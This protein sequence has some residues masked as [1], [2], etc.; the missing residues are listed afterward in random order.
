LLQKEI[1]DL[2]WIITASETDALVLE[3]TLIKK[4]S[5]KY[6]VRLKDDKRYPWICVTVSE[7]FPRVFIARNPKD[8]GNRY[9]GPFVDV[10]ATRHFLQTIYK[11]FPVRKKNL[12]LPLKKPAR[13]C[14]NFHIGRCLGPCQGNVSR[15]EYGKLVEQILFFLD[16]N[17][18]IRRKWNL[19]LRRATGT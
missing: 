9:F 15:E 4:Y 17:K 3:A 6:N 1:F 19:K 8:D 12:K 18:K 5:P 13:P 16:G 7:S 11:I 14:V 2:E 10:R